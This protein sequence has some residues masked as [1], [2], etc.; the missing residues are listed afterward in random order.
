MK[1]DRWRQIESLCHRDLRRL[2]EAR[3]SAIAQEHRQWKW[4]AALAMLVIVPVVVVALTKWAT[5]VRRSGAGLD[6]PQIRSIAVLPLRNV[7]RDAD[8]EYFADGMTDV[9]TTSLAHISG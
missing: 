8:Q 6:R 2:T 7:S 5:P 1:P 3:S 9:L 4:I